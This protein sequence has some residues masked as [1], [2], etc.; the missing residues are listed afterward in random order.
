MHLPHPAALIQGQN[1]TLRERPWRCLP[2][3]E[4]RDSSMV[5]KPTRHLLRVCLICAGKN[6][7]ASTLAASRSSPV[8]AIIVTG[9]IEGSNAVVYYPMNDGAELV[10]RLGKNIHRALLTLSIS[11]VS[12]LT[13]K[14]GEAS[15][16]LCPTERLKIFIQKLIGG[17]SVGNFLDFHRIQRKRCAIELGEIRSGDRTVDCDGR[18]SRS[19]RACLRSS[20]D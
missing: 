13:D 20:P 12:P 4:R 6:R 15:Q 16:P 3:L 8:I 19:P 5:V 9:P 17:G 2:L 14:A 11:L 7:F 18:S 10:R 1:I